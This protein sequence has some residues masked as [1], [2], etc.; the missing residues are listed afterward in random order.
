M[1]KIL[2]S[3][4]VMSL[5]VLSG[6]QQ[7]VP[8]QS[9][10]SG[11]QGT[12][13]QSSAAVV[14]ADPFKADY[15]MD[16]DTMSILA[17]G[18]SLE[19]AALSTPFYG[20]SQVMPLPILTQFTKLRLAK[21]QEAMQLSQAVYDNALK[22]R[23]AMEPLKESN[24]E[25]LA[26]ALKNDVKLQKFAEGFTGQLG[27]YKVKETM[28]ETSIES[29]KSS[30]SI[31]LA[32]STSEYIKTGLEMEY[33]DT[34]KEDF[35]VFLVNSAKLA[36]A[37]ELVQNETLK[38][39]LTDFNARMEKIGDT[40]N[41]LLVGIQKNIVLT[42]VALRQI[43]TGD[44]YM[45]LAGLE[46][47]R[48]NLPALKEQ[49]AALKPGADVEQGDIDIIKEYIAYYD[50]YVQGMMGQL[51]KYD[52]VKYTLPL[53]V[54]PKTTSWV[55]AA[56]A[57]IVDTASWAL[58][59]IVDTADAMATKVENATSAAI[60]TGVEY[61]QAGYQAVKSGTISAVNYGAEVAQSTAHGIASAYNTV[62]TAIDPFSPETWQ[63][64]K[65]FSN[66]PKT[67]V[68]A[69]LDEASVETR[70][71]LEKTIGKYWYGKSDE[72]IAEI[73]KELRQKQL[74]NVLLGTAGSETL[75]NAKNGMELVENGTAG[76]VEKGFEKV[77]DKG[78][79]SWGANKVTN[80][81]VG[82]F[83]SL[84][85]GLYTLA[86]PTSSNL[87]NAGAVFDIGFS[88]LG[89]SKSVVK[90]SSVISGTAEAGA[91][92]ID[93]AA[94]W[95]AKKFNNNKIAALKSQLKA[96]EEVLQN[97]EITKEVRT[98][99]RALQ[100]KLKGWI[101]NA[102]GD[103]RQLAETGDVIRDRLKNIFTPLLPGNVVKSSEKEMLDALKGAVVQQFEHGLEGYYDT[104]KAMVGG[105][106]IDI[107]N[108]VFGGSLD[109]KVSDI[110]K[111][112]LGSSLF[113]WNVVLC[114]GKYGGV[115]KFQGG[116]F[117]VAGM[118]EGNTFSASG[119]YVMTY[120][121][122]VVATVF[123]LQGTVDNEGKMSGTVN[124]GGSIKGQIK[125]KSS[126]G[127]SFTG[128]CDGQTIAL[129]YD[130]SG[131]TNI[132]GAGGYGGGTFAGGAKGKLTLTR[133]P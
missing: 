68:G 51:E 93:K 102:V 38:P 120:Y 89:G 90:G 107:F 130:V 9:N 122:V 62:S 41:P 55:P 116:S 70:L 80:M 133:A 82:A 103:D 15:V 40:I 110:M 121:G 88:L 37:L 92:F 114:D 26:Q 49:L 72:H 27:F 131:I 73:E 78:W 52:Y 101:G 35:Y 113:P 28:L 25:L 7:G 95:L 108:N 76:L 60:S 66:L 85:K 123:G 48:Q 50:S 125:G 21:V 18:D 57:G 8:N 97:P 53:S 109:G 83:T 29:M 124:G 100:K 5:V 22:L 6:C 19:D 94:T 61:G 71:G 104:F 81:A 3:L 56:R 2:S 115:W 16:K 67:L 45:T 14:P 75:Q 4:L 74:G 105:N 46:Y 64:I 23:D 32:D 119:S 112:L 106:P 17:D 12:T 111:G 58:G 63:Q 33:G 77:F 98:A 47:M 91:G 34:V 99:T 132:S 24:L 54:N 10:T 42:S 129:D 86:D 126:G 44:Y 20:G 11:Q 84:A 87:D 79:M 127:G 30:S 117:P 13:S 96:A 128:T 39:A 118:I 1:K 65:F 36:Q 31:A 69:A 59:G 43:D